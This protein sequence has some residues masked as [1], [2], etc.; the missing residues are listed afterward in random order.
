[1]E[2]AEEDEKEE[3]PKNHLKCGLCKEGKK[4]VLHA[5]EHLGLVSSL[6]RLERF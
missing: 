4:G 6:G 1:M 5:L 3:E 2:D